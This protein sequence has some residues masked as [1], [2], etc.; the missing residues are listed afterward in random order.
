[1]NGANLQVNHDMQIVGVVITVAL[2]IILFEVIPE[3]SIWS[4]PVTQADEHIIALPASGGSSL[5]LMQK[6]GEERKAPT[7]E[8]NYNKQ[9]HYIL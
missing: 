8:Q 6:Q 2:G 5:L 3:K 7:K 9:H 4:I 1:M